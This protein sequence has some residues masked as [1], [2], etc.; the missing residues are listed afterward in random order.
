MISINA[1]STHHVGQQT[2]FMGFFKFFFLR[3][4]HC[5]L[6]D[7]QCL[8]P[9]TFNIV[10]DLCKQRSRKEVQKK[11]KNSLQQIF[12]IKLKK[13]RKMFGSASSNPKGGLDVNLGFGKN[14]GDAAS[15]AGAGAYA[16]GNTGGGP[17][18]TGVFLEANKNNHGLTL[19]HSKTD[20]FGSNLTSSAHANL[21]K[22][23]TH[24]LKAN[25][26][27]S[28]THLDNG[29]KFDCV[30]GGLGYNH[31]NGHGAAL[32]GSRI[33][34]LD[35]NSLNITGKANL[36]TSPN[37]STTLDLT[38]GATKHFGGPFDGQTNKNFGLGLNT[39]F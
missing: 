8:A 7:K 1:K 10:E 18:T 12:D 3:L 39:K 30:G 29:F 36:W 11:K 33:P 28:R 19:E 15:N 17:T 27:H 20:K 35:M 38:G 32:T 13:K 9:A 23:D 4:L 16:A 5:A 14:V 31:V 34:Q 37:R 21:L 26:F 2:A 22:N 6:E 25:A 24:Q